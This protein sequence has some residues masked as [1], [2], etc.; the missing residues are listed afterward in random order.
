MPLGSTN[1]YFRLAANGSSTSAG[2]YTLQYSKSGDNNNEYT[3]IPP[4]TLVVSNKECE[5]VTEENSYSLPLGGSTLPI[6][7]DGIKCIP[8]DSITI[9]IS[10]TS[11]EVTMNSDLSSNVLS[12]TSEDG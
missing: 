9:G 12:S 7:I 1:G 6:N 8:I 10:S 2:L 5:L 3:G 4:L 11:A